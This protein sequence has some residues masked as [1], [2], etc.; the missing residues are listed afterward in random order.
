MT[1]REKLDDL[2]FEISERIVNPLDYYLKFSLDDAYAQLLTSVLPVIGYGMA[3]ISLG[4]YL[5]II[6]PLDLQNP[7]WE[8]QTLNSLVRQSWTFLLSIGLI[9]SRY[10]TDNKNDASAFDLFLLRV[11]RWVVLTMAI[12]FFF[13]IP[14]IIVDTHRLV[15]YNTKQID[16]KEQNQLKQIPAVK[17]K[18]NQTSDV[19]QMALL[20]R[21]LG[22]NVQDFVG[23]PSI[24]VQEILRQRLIIFESELKQKVKEAK[25]EKAIT[26]WKSSLR[27]IFAGSMISLIFIFIW[28]RIGVIYRLYG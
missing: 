7:A 3:L 26:L 15:S 8:L 1:F 16:Q 11:I 12:M 2:R 21:A 25:K 10:L 24:Q 6:Y 18:L 14:L 20:G 9:F 13:T 27:T 23:K 19:R 22:L 17:A 28:R 5:Y 4:D